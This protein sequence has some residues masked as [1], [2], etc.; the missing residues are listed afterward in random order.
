ML[1]GKLITLRLITEKDLPLL[2]SFGNDLREYSPIQGVHLQPEQTV[3]QRYTEGAY[4]SEERGWMLITDA[5]DGRPL[6]E[7]GFFRNAPY[8]AG[9]EIGYRIAKR[10]DRGKGYMTEALRL[11]AAYLFE[12]KP[13]PRLQV[14][15]ATENAAS[16][17]VAEKAG[18]VYEGTLRKASFVRGVYRDLAVYGMVKSEAPALKDVLAP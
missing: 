18:F 11:F 9:F 16:R 3:R 15:I 2:A 8:R 17:R 10:A 7:I 13:I 4:W 5:R 12:L 6:G 14:V 1:V